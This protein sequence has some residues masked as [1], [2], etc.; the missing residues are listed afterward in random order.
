MERKLKLLPKYRILWHRHLELYHREGGRAYTC[1]TRLLYNF[2]FPFQTFI[3]YNYTKELKSALIAID[4]SPDDEHVL[5]LERCFLTGLHV[6]SQ[7]SLIDEELSVLQG[8]AAHLTASDPVLG[9]CMEFSTLIRILS[10]AI[11]AYNSGVEARRRVCRCS[12]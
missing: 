4:E 12:T 1:C 8:L 3:L 2:F 7:L 11:I 6:F 9:R 10:S 5:I